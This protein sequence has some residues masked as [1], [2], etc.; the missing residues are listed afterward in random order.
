MQPSSSRLP[1]LALL[2]G[3]F[4]AG[5]LPAVAQQSAVDTAQSTSTTQQLQKPLQTPAAA[6][7]DVPL[8]YEGEN[9]DVGTQFVLQPKPKVNYFQAA[10]D[11]QVYRSDNPTLAPAN[12]TASDITVLTVQAAVQSASSEWFDGVM[13]QSRLG[14]RFQDYWYGVISGRNQIITGAPVKYSDFTTLSPYGEISLRSD[15]WYGTVGLRYSSY[16]NNN[17]LASGTFYQEWVPSG[18]LGYQMNVAAHQTV[19][20]Q[21]DVDYRRTETKTGG[22]LPT[23]WNDRVDN[24]LSIIYSDIIGD[25][26]VIQP[27]YRIMWSKYTLPQRNRSDVYDTLSFLV[28]YYFNPNL[29]ARAFTSYEWRSS[30]EPGNNYGNWNLGAGL[31]V[32]A[33]F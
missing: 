20:F 16:D 17:A 14:F 4:L 30:S 24:A 13:G 7:G 8:L 11:V 22:L 27:S 12:K 18:T 32:S 31:S 21:Y 28:A 5:A 19:Q 23:S 33:S 6:Q 9:E 26:W 10:G 1:A 3:L 29:S 25:H 15:N 2:T